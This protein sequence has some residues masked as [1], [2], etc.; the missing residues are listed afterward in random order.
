[1]QQSP[2]KTRL[3]TI[4]QDVVELL[5]SNAFN[6]LL[7]TILSVSAIT[8][9]FDSG[10]GQ[11]TKQRVWGIILVFTLIR[12]LDA[13]YWFIKLR[14]ANYAPELPFYRFFVGSIFTAVLWAVFGISFFDSM[15]TLEFASTM[16]IMSAMAGGAAT[17]LAPSMLLVITYTTIML[18]PMSLRAIYDYRDEYNML[19]FLGILFWISMCGAS[20]RANLFIRRAIEI[21]HKNDELVDLMRNEQNEVKRVNLQLLESNQKLDQANNNLENEVLRRTQE[22]HQ[23]SNRDPLTGLMNR[24]AFMQHFEWMI[25]QSVPSKNKLAILFIDLDGFKQIND[26]FGHESGDAVL[27]AVATQLSQFCE[28]DCAGRWGGDEFIMVLPYADEVAATAIGQAARSS[29]ANIKQV[30][31]NDVSIGA[32]IGIAIYPNHSE[33]AATLVQLADLTMYFHKRSTPG[34]VGVF[35]DSLY[36]TLN[37]EV[38]LRDGLRQAI[39]RQEIHV[40]YQPIIE[41]GTKKLWAV[42]ALARWCFHDQWISPAVFIPL[43]EKTGLIQDIGNWILHRACIDTAQWPDDS[44]SVSVNVSVLQMLNDNFIRQVDQA[45]NSSGLAPHRLHLEVTESIFA[46]D[47]AILTDR[48]AALKARHIHIAIDDFGTGFSSLS[49]LQALDFD[50]LKIDRAF[51]QQIT[52]GNDTIVR[53]TLLMAKEFGCKTVAEGIETPEQAA[54]LEAMGVDCLQGYLFAKPLEKNDLIKWYTDQHHSKHNSQ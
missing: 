7:I 17:V 32:T 25:K 31:G 1:M 5:Y 18:I 26:T 22:I 2:F 53:A 38:R 41:A 44:L 3:N 35:S 36:D 28:T 12:G 46:D 6:G 52:E 51:V 13:A 11:E 49:L 29:L 50:L 24:T 4:N 15:S 21:K 54:I 39:Q 23:L 34:V 33:D 20:S 8:F 14:H 10:A 40:V 27:T 19:G 9:G 43:A 42:E 47:M 37:E 45:I 16:I 48:I 30:G